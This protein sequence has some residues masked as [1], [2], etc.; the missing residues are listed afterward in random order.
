M[1]YI[2][3]LFSWVSTCRTTD[4]K[5][6]DNL[7]TDKKLFAVLCHSLQCRT[8]WPWRVISYFLLGSFHR[9]FRVGLLKRNVS[10]ILR[11]VTTLF[12]IATS[13]RGKGPFLTPTTNRGYC[14]TSGCSSD[15]LGMK[16]HLGVVWNGHFS[17][18]E[19]DHTS[20]PKFK[21][22]FNFFGVLFINL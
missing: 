18:Y 21:D 10:A 3:C 2:H 11:A 5:S 4:H 8:K 17:Y 6:W 15:L 13:D 12:C 22:R 7:L 9:F 20:S 1:W 14:Q 19:W 16:R